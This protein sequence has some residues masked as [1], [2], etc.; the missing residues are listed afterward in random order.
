[1]P[2]GL[3]DGEAGGVFF[4]HGEDEF[5][6]DEVARAL[7]ER[8]LDPS[9]RDF[10]FDPL[11]GD[12]VEVEDLASILATPPMMAE[13][14]VVLLRQTEALA[15]SSRARELLVGTAEDPPPG[16]ALI[17]VT[18]V[19]S[20]SSARFYKDLKKK[21]RAVGFPELS[22]NDVPGWLLAR[23]REHHGLEMDEEAAR[24][25]GGAV[26]TDLGVL[27]Q[28]ME[29]LAGVAGERD[30][31][32]LDDVKTAGTRLPEQDRW[33]WFDLVGKRRFSEALDGLRVLLEQGGESGV[34]LA[35]GLGTHLLRVG[36][37]AEG[38]KAA[39]EKALPRHLRGW[40]APKLASQARLWSGEEIEEAL[41][42]LRRADRLLK[43]SSFPDRLVLEE[44]LL[45]LMVPAE[46]EAA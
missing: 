14:R 13:W 9:T 38:G 22:A 16:L 23:A 7:V 31:I 32:T 15:S 10:N 24:A 5:R 46:D 12:D 39:L 30:R 44:W 8:H 45:G 43:S 33:D 28:E 1:M 41:V 37:G 3:A 6:K 29:K 42:G 26:G 2:S 4:L 21:A 35:I 25:L 11:R 27:A 19:P 36:V 18:T 34:G 40:L 17:L 20:S